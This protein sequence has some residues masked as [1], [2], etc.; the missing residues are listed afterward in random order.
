VAPLWNGLVTQFLHEEWERARAEGNDEV[1]A[2]LIEDALFLRTTYQSHLFATALGQHYGLPTTGLDVTSQLLPALFFA[3]V[4][5]ERVREGW[6]T[7]VP[8]ANQGG[9]PVL[10]ILLPP[11]QNTNA[12]Y[13]YGPSDIGINRP[14]AQ[15]A[16]FM[17]SGWGTSANDAARRI[18]LALYLDFDPEG[19]IELPKSAELFPAQGNDRFGDFVEKTSKRNIPEALKEYLG[20]FYWVINEGGV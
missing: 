15:S 8:A 14:R 18:L 20:R 19:Q 16:H 11:P 3:F 10:Y 6:F 13:T 12:Y 4:S 2:T 5:L 17:H 7:A 1:A 9:L